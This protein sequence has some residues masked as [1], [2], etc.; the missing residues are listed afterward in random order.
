MREDIVIGVSADISMYERQMN[1]LSDSTGRGMS[2]SARQVEALSGEMLSS[3][4]ALYE[5]LERL[6]ADSFGQRSERLD[7]WYRDSVQVNGDLAVLADEASRTHGRS[8]Q[9][10]LTA[11]ERFLGGVRQGYDDLQD[12]LTDWSDG[13]LQVFQAFASQSAT[14]FENSLFAVLKGRFDDIGDAWQSLVDSMLHA[15]LGMIGEMAAQSLAESV[16]G[17]LSGGSVSGGIL[18]A[19]GLSSEGLSLS[20][21]I[22]SASGIVDNGIDLISS[23]VEA[24]GNFFGGL[25][26]RAS[27]STAAPV[28]LYQ[29]RSDGIPSVSSGSGGNLSGPER[30]EVHIHGDTLADADTLDRVALKIGDALSRR[31]RRY[32]F[33]GG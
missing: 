28:P 30:I 14:F 25:F 19:L 31:Q 24:V 32:S 27:E 16:V 22:S 7:E 2:Q 6:S 5:E 18:S 11:S 3:H 1:R 10:K 12:H 23:G 13:G 8:E 26:D 17:L 20:S 15:F 29:P 21:L 9:D 33:Q 4:G